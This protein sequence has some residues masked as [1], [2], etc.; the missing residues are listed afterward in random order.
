MRITEV[1][2]ARKW[3]L[4][5]AVWI[6]VLVF[7]VTNSPLQRGIAVDNLIEWVGILGIVLCIAGR[8]WC[9]LYIG[10]R[11][12]EQLVMLGPY[13]IVRN[14]LYVFSIIGAAGAGAQHG[15]VVVALVLGVLAWLVFYAVVLQEERL[16]TDRYGAAYAAYRAKVPRFLPKPGLWHDL[17]TLT[18]MPPRVLRT[19]GDAMFF[20]LAIP[21]ADA[22]EHLQNIGVLP[23]LF[24]LP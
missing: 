14:P 13:S 2:T 8:T 15:S 1:Q 7:A 20:L 5:T 19:F 17:P 4:G 9:S 3:V 11:K 22:L 16:L 12:I 18:I 10:G 23:I 24:R 6:S 21:M